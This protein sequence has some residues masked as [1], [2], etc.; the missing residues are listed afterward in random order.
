M[1]SSGLPGHTVLLCFR[2]FN[3]LFFKHTL[4]ISRLLFMSAQQPLITNAIAAGKTSETMKPLPVK[5]KRSG[6]MK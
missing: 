3:V 6:G 4:E 2:Q 1:Q 5:V